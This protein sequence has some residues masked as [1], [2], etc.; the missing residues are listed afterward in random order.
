MIELRSEPDK[1]TKQNSLRL[2]RIKGVKETQE[3][4]CGAGEGRGTAGRPRPPWLSAACPEGPCLRIQKKNATTI[5]IIMMLLR[6]LRIL[7]FVYR[8]AGQPAL[9][10]L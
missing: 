8:P 3:L 10:R 7:N 6:L 5:I 9:L 4:F 2:R 1:Q